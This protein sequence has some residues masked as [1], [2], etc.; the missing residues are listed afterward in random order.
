V[1]VVVRMAMVENLLIG[2]L[3]AALGAMSLNAMWN[4][5][6]EV[7]MPELNSVITIAPATFGWAIFIGV[8]VVA[9]TPVLV[10]RRLAG[11][12]IPSTLRVIE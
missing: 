6:M 12:D 11:M 8:I 1:N 2:I 5:R 9:L 7:M 4:M 3:G 10:A